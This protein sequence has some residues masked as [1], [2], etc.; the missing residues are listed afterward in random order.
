MSDMVA[1]SVGVE[2]VCGNATINTEFFR[3]MAVT[4]EMDDQDLDTVNKLATGKQDA[5]LGA[6]DALG[7]EKWCS[8]QLSVLTK[9]KVNG[10]T[11]MEYSK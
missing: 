9:E 1:Q 10:I 11:P 8:R 2:L 7:K 6:V 5:V 4:L 3:Q